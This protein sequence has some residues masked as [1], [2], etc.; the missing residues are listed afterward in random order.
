MHCDV[1]PPGLLLRAFATPEGARSGL[2][3]PGARLVRAMRALI[4]DVDGTVAETE[5]DGH[6]V[7][8]NQAFEAAGLPWRWS[9][10]RYGELLQVTGGRERLLHD[11]TQHADAPPLGAERDALARRLHALKNQRYAQ[12]V[13]QGGIVARPGVLRLMDECA[14]A[15]VPL[16]VATTTSRGNVVALFASLFG[17][18]WATRFATVV[19]AQDAPRKKPH[20]QVYQLALQRLGL[21]GA[22]AFALED[23]PNGLAAARAAGVAC[24]ITR[25]AY[26]AHAQFEGAALVQDDLESPLPITLARLQQLRG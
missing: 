13:A 19:C 2:G 1:C 20:P 7:A 26:F 3:R 23:S 11:M 14:R 22:D 18:A 15:G 9:V 8:F 16:A 10:E 6:R 21:V 4:W 5:R 12:L 24:A 17:P 25:S